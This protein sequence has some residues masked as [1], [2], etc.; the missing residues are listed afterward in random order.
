MLKKIKEK[1]ITLIA[2]VVTIIVL[3]ILAAVSI[4]MITGENGILTNTL[5]AKKETKKA[6]YFE[7]I[8]IEIT[9]EQLERK[10][11]EKEESF[12][13]SIKSRIEE[14][15]WINGVK[16]KQD[17]DS[18]IENILIVYT[19]DGYEIIIDVNNDDLT[20]TIRNYFEKIGEQPQLEKIITA[21]LNINKQKLTK[22]TIINIDVIAQNTK[23]KKVELI[24]GDKVIYLDDEKNETSYNKQL[25]TDELSKLNELEF[26]N[27]YTLVLSVT[28][29][30]KEV[31]EKIENIKN[32][33]IGNV[34]SIKKLSQIVNNE[35]GFSGETIYQVSDIDLNK[36]KW[37]V[38]VHGRTVFVTTA[39][40]WE[41]IG[42]AEFE[43]TSSKYFN[44]KAFE[45][46]YDGNNKKIYGLYINDSTL[47]YGGLFGYSKGIIRNV[48]LLNSKISNRYIAG[49]ICGRDLGKIE[50]CQNYSNVKASFTVGGI[51]GESNDIANCTNNGEIENVKQ[52]DEYNA[53]GGI[54]GW[55]ENSITNCQ[56][57]GTITTI[58]DNSENKA[59][60]T[61]GV[62]GAT[63]DAKI[64]SCYNNG[65]IQGA[66][67]AG[68]IIGLGQ[69]SKY[70]TIDSCY[71]NGSVASND[72]S[73]GIISWGDVVDIT[74]CYNTGNISGKNI[75]GITYW[76]AAN[77]NIENCYNIG[78]IAETE[79]IVP[80]LGYWEDNVILKNNYVSGPNKI[81]NNA[82]SN[83]N[84]AGMI[85]TKSITNFQYPTTNKSSVA[86]L[87]NEKKE[88]GVW[89]QNNSVNSKY[90]YLTYNNQQ[91]S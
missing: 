91:Q 11:R 62:I 88:E 68:G 39:I 20:A 50:Y 29:E 55:L 24:L 33:T 46:I 16:S 17:I 57:Y 67:N 14:K 38:D 36:G 74:N 69:Q 30:N 25:K 79:E 72:I 19:K 80:L 37:S 64:T 63:Y 2:L 65:I 90:P 41:P 81:G 61:G 89:S 34:E 48:I 35:Q 8:N 21:T 18:D 51:A 32:F 73:G 3:L 31:K 7:E 87:L 26:Y 23:I 78:K 85:E 83:S 66:N 15:N 86:Y 40:Q 70:L 49:G 56:N 28:S 10:L 44:E 52:N 42:H 13:N 82:S 4:A 22:D 60:G 43:I 75:G 77:S 5:E 12:I 76:I 6:Q 84:L 1:G 45:G 9:N 47:D 71:N 54:V 27:D 53:T 58:V 59:S